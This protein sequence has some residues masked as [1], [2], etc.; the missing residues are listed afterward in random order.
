MSGQEQIRRAPNGLPLFFVI[1]PSSHSVPP[2][3]F[4]AHV[5]HTSPP[6]RVIS[7]TTDSAVFSLR[8]TLHWCL[9]RRLYDLPKQ[10]FK[11]WGRRPNNNVWLWSWRSSKLGQWERSTTSFDPY[12]WSSASRFLFISLVIL[13]CAAS[14][15]ANSCGTL[16]TGLLEISLKEHVGGQPTPRGQR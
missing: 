5:P 14:C 4:V 9:T 10:G 6:I 16:E 3:P 7:L 15:F 8:N 11:I 2:P 13:C 1:S 12:P